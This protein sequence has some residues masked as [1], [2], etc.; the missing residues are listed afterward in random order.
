MNQPMEQR[1]KEWYAT[2]AGKFTASA[3]ADLMATTRSGPSASRTNLIARL[4]VERLT[5]GIDTDLNYTSAAMQRGIDLEP[6]ARIA[7]EF[8]TGQHVEQVAFVDHAI[9]KN[10]GCSPDGLIG[11]DGLVEIKCPGQTKHID[12]LR[13]GAH[14]RE[15][16][17]Q[18][19][20]QLWVTG[21]TW[22]DAVSYHPSFPPHLQLAIGRV[23]RDQGAIGELVEAVRKAEIEITGII[24]ELT[25]LRSA[26]A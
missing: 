21:R 14:A 10:C 24:E 11:E 9:V 7:Y 1:S 25:Q 4:A 2:R 23:E 8:H 6:E 15:Y 20:G 17:W 13:T 5:G 19:Q 12:A 16:R 26:A 3:F 22:V 18:L